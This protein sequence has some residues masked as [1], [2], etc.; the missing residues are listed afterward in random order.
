MRKKINEDFQKRLAATRRDL[1]TNK[2]R[3]ARMET[4]LQKRE[5]KRDKIVEAI[6]LNRLSDNPRSM[7]DKR[8]K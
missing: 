2:K 5:K 1:E 4:E 3:I 6:L 8:R 7:P